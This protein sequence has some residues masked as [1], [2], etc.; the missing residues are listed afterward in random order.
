MSKGVNNTIVLYYL[1]YLTIS[2][3]HIITGLVRV[4][5]IILSYPLRRSRLEK[6][7]LVPMPQPTHHFSLSFSNSSDKQFKVKHALVVRPAPI[8]K[9][10]VQNKGH[11]KQPPKHWRH[12][13][14]RLQ[15]ISSFIIFLCY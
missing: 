9:L 8:R 7:Q 10:P 11:P 1:F 12:P 2:V 14:V 5:L 15:E 4:L 13:N 3:W 6:A